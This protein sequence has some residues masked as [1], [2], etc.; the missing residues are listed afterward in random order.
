MQHNCPL[1]VECLD[2]GF[3]ANINRV[4][5]EQCQYVQNILY[6]PGHFVL[7]RQTNIVAQIYETTHY[8]T[9][10]E[11]IEGTLNLD[12]YFDDVLIEH[13]RI[14]V[15]GSIKSQRKHPLIKSGL[16]EG[17]FPCDPHIPT[18]T[19]C[20]GNIWLR[21]SKPVPANHKIVASYDYYV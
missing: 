6:K 17:T 5:H 8:H 2:S 3:W 14:T 11:Y 13:C 15:N 1:G 21:W 16:I 10:I 20:N 4:H 19:K 9:S 12:I 18:L 7:N